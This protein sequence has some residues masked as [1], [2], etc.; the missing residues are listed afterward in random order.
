[1]KSFRTRLRARYADTDATGIVYHGSYQRYF[2]VGRVE[3]FRELG[4]PYDWR[5]P[6]V[7]TY[8]RFR[9]S[10]RFDDLLEV[11][12]FVEEVRT[13]AFR[14]GQQV[15]RLEHGGTGAGMATAGPAAGGGAP[16]AAHPALPELLVEGHTVMMT[17]DGSGPIALPPRFRAALGASPETP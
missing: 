9:A 12:S 2:E 4:L 5:L 16:A 7:E 6:I 14:I 8:C 1:M 11:R 15:H 13:R 10:A 3:M 17:R